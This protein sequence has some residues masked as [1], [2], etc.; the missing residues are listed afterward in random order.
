[1]N[2]GMD[3]TTAS[4]PTKSVPE[5]IY[6]QP[7]EKDHGFRTRYKLVTGPTTAFHKNKKTKAADCVRPMGETIA[8]VEDYKNPVNW[9]QPDDLTIEE[10]IE[11]FDLENATVR[12]QIRN[13]FYVLDFYGNM[14]GFLDGSVGFYGFLEEPQQIADY[15][16]ISTPSK[17]DLDSLPFQHPA[18][19]SQTL[20]SRLLSS[21]TKHCACTPTMLF[22]T[23][24]SP[25]A[26]RSGRR[27]IL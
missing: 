11:L 18:N 25:I 14:A 15:F 24:A 8:V 21:R 5:F 10:A 17:N 23:T 9:M 20:Y 27:L 16:S 26:R 13:K 7:G 4:S 6:F 19:T 3:Q 12:D 2:R 1:M 22:Q